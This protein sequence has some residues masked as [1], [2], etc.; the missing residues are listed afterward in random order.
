MF[1]E[2]AKPFEVKLATGMDGRTVWVCRD[3][4]HINLERA[5]ELFSA[6]MSVR[7]V[8]EEL[9]ISKSTAHRLRMKWKTSQHEKSS[10]G[11]DPMNVEHRDG[12]DE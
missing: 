3:L 2:G 5:I 7:D 11:P 4:E 8:A 1:A 9:S 6:G 12:E 10:Q